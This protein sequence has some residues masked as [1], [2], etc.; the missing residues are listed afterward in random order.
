MECMIT[1][2][3]GIRGFVILVKAKKY[4]Y[5]MDEKMEKYIATQ[6]WG[7]IWVIVSNKEMIRPPGHGF[8]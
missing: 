1:Q 3:N 2:L 8:G 5:Y 6:Q 4:P 7:V